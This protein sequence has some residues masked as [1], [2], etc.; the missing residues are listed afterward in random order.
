MIAV[1]LDHLGVDQ[2]A[3]LSTGEQ[4]FQDGVVENIQTLE[5]GIDALNSLAARSKTHRALL[6]ALPRSIEQIIAGVAASDW[7]MEAGN[8]AAAAAFFE[9]KEPGISQAKSQIARLRLES[10]VSMSDGLSNARG[11]TLLAALL[12]DVRRWQQ[13]A[14]SNSGKRAEGPRL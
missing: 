5:L 4:Q 10:I 13:A 12:H 2:Q 7:I 9:S 11:E 1:A 8:Q 14:F 6:L 3:F